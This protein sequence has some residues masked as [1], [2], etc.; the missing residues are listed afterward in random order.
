MFLQYYL[1]SFLITTCIVMCVAES[2]FLIR[3]NV[4]FLYDECTQSGFSASV[5]PLSMSM[6]YFLL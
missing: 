2:N 5:L 4:V 6:F 1:E 3:Q